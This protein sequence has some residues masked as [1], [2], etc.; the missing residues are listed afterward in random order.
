LR[1]RGLNAIPVVARGETHVLGRDLAE[2]DRLFGWRSTP[3]KP[4]PAADLV[5]RMQM[6]LRAAARYA[7]Q[8]PPEHYGDVIPGQEHVSGPLMLA[9]GSVLRRSDGSH[10]I[11][12]HTYFD[13][14]AHIAGHGDKFL[15]LALHPDSNAFS[16]IETFAPLG[17]PG[18]DA[19]LDEVCDQL[20]EAA[21]A[22]GRLSGGFSTRDLAAPVRSPDG[23]TTLHAMLDSM[24]YSTAQHSRQL[25]AVLELLGIEP[26]GPLSDADYEGL[27]LPVTTWG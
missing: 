18:A 27:A 4:L 3:R 10:Y 26:D 8:L 12:H 23:L 22:I 7:R 16:R 19:T 6:L 15:H 2:I 20:A 5:Y 14:A 1:K 21:D 11:P 13:L 9:D 25:L 17:E 24:T